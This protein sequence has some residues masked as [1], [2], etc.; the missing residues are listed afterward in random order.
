GIATSRP[1]VVP[2]RRDVAPSL[3]GGGL[4][5]V[6]V[7]LERTLQMAA[8]DRRS[9]GLH[10]PRAPPLGGAVEPRAAGGGPPPGS[11]GRADRSL[12]RAPGGGHDR[13]AAPAAGG[14]G[15]GGGSPPRRPRSPLRPRGHGGGEQLHPRGGLRGRRQGSPPAPRHHHPR[16]R[17]ARG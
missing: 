3:G 13:P 6:E 14:V 9:R 8:P 11:G 15:G 17:Q 12:P 4:L 5:R 1:D 10:E 2:G 7:T 16:D